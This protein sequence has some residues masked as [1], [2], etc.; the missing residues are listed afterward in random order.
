M[1][2]QKFFDP[3]DPDSQVVVEEEVNLFK[4]PRRRPH[5]LLWGLLVA[6][7]AVAALLLLRTPHPPAE[8]NDFVSGSQPHSGSSSAL[9]PTPSPSPTPRPTVTPQPEG[10][11]AGEEWMLRIASPLSPL[12]EDY[13]E[14]EMEA[15][16]GGYY[17]DGRA[18]AAVKELLAAAAADGKQLG[19][20]SAYRGVEKQTSLHERAVRGFVSTGHTQQEA[21]E[22]AD[23]AQPVYQECEH[24]LGLALDFSAPGVAQESLEFIEAE[25]FTW[26]QEHAAEYGFVLRYPQDKEEITGL[27]Y[28]PWHFRYVG[29]QHAQAMRQQNLCLE[30]YVALLAGE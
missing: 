8:E 20:Y 17:F 28:K 22:L 4:S 27:S 29:V 21:E 16:G 2:T 23:A 18:A 5:F 9:Q 7:C 13:G 12:P 19:I 26:L 6:G 10:I 1:P 14:Q 30:E 15:L 24:S 25:E 3:E 11:P